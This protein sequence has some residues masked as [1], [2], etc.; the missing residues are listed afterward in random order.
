MKKLC[1]LFFICNFYTIYTSQQQNRLT[2]HVFLQPA[3]RDEICPSLQTIAS[4]ENFLDTIRSL[5]DNHHNKTTISSLT[6][7]NQKIIRVIIIRHDGTPQIVT[8]SLRNKTQS[9]NFQSDSIWNIS[10]TYSMPDEIATILDSLDETTLSKKK[11]ERLH[12]I[13]HAQTTD[14]FTSERYSYD[15]QETNLVPEPSD[16]NTSEI[17]P[18]PSQSKTGEGSQN[19]GHFIQRSPHRFGSESKSSAVKKDADTDTDKETDLIPEPPKF[20]AQRRQRSNSLPDEQ[21]PLSQYRGQPYYPKK[22]RITPS[23]EPRKP[24]E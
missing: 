1:I 14:S 19:N 4:F 10:D 6:S 24:S 21:V 9:P 16:D 20:Q 7:H 18:F 12:K 17:S 2:C 11:R 23:P 8:Y 13:L 22:F 3:D 5:G 15:Y